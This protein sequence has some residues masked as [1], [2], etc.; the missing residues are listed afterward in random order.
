MSLSS[1]R[2]RLDGP[3]MAQEG[4]KGAQDGS[5]RAPGDGPDGLK[6]TQRPPQAGSKA[7]QKAVAL[8][9]EIWS[10][11][12]PEK[13]NKS[14]LSLHRNRGIDSD[15]NGFALREGCL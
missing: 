15:S 13:R 5:R 7:R 3:K 1:L 9:C 6:T 12:D 4:P 10:E 11:V 2:V 8:R 14:P